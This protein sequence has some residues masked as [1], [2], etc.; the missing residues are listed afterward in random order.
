VRV[1]IVAIPHQR[2]ESYGADLWA[3]PAALAQRDAGA[4]ARVGSQFGWGNRGLFACASDA[5]STV[6][7]GEHHAIRS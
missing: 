6:L 3:T 4:L 2:K 1:V 5:F 7:N